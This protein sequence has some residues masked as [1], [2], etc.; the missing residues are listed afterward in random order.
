MGFN[1]EHTN[2]F[3]KYVVS[4]KQTWMK[5]VKFFKIKIKPVKYFASALFCFFGKTILRTKLLHIHMNLFLGFHFTYSL[6]IPTV[7]CYRNK[8]LYFCIASNKEKPFF[9]EDAFMGW[10]ERSKFSLGIIT[11]IYMPINSELISPKN[12]MSN[13]LSHFKIFYNLKKMWK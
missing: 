11:M 5:G 13:S 10:Q 1:L 9:L 2:W 7:A 4:W 3:N 8:I 12:G 6:L